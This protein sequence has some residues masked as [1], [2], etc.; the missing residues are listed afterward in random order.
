MSRK[1]HKQMP[2][3]FFS[4]NRLPRRLPAVSSSPAAPLMTR[5]TASSPTAS[6]SGFFQLACGIPAV[7]QKR[8]MQAIAAWS[9]DDD[10]DDVAVHETPARNDCISCEPGASR[11]TGRAIVNGVPGE[12][13]PRESRTEP[14]SARMYSNDSVRQAAV[15][16]CGSDGEEH[17][18]AA[19]SCR[20]G[21]KVSPLKRHSTTCVQDRSCD[22]NEGHANGHSDTRSDQ[23]GDSQQQGGSSGR[24]NHIEHSTPVPADVQ[25]DPA[26][27]LAAPSFSL[28]L[29]FDEVGVMAGS[30]AP[31][32][33]SLTK[34]GALAGDG[35]DLSPVAGVRSRE[36]RR[37]SCS[38]DERGNDASHGARMRNEAAAAT[39]TVEAGAAATATIAAAAAAAAP[40]G[41][42]GSVAD[43]GTDGARS[44]SGKSPEAPLKGNGGSQG[45]H[46]QTHAAG[47][48]NESEGGTEGDEGPLKEEW[49]EGDTVVG[50]A[51]GCEPEGRERRFKRLRKR[52]SEGTPTTESTR[53]SS[54][55]RNCRE[56]PVARRD[57]GI[58]VKSEGR[59]IGRENSKP[60]AGMPTAADRQRHA[61]RIYQPG[62]HAAMAR[63]Q[64]DGGLDAKGEQLRQP[65]MGAADLMARVVP[66]TEDQHLAAAGGTEVAIAR[67]E[68]VCAATGNRRE[69]GRWWGQLALDGVDE[70]EDGLDS[71]EACA[72]QLS[73]C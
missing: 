73:T 47:G 60:A 37:H 62:P 46:R 71:Q 54:F 26:F 50:R 8:R 5:S 23:Q 28:G 51:M 57:G 69:M 33:D 40:A 10:D 58:G 30:L 1:R 70:I 65:A 41:N 68:G 31:E 56:S 59:L 64:G 34:Q 19:V 39:A 55:P 43:S 27:F 9:D 42:E 63:Q 48:E 18:H 32:F 38:D 35:G 14:A 36:Q 25:E 13:N 4:G 44:G 15:Q 7:T 16:Q 3:E 21:S 12:L 2:L 66:D 6:P 45:E 67:G 29:G 49:M 53:G 22:C 52:Q 20:S 61:G 17:R 11:R 24:G 72:G